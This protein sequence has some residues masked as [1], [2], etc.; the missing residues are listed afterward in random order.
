M[1]VIFLIYAIAMPGSSNQYQVH[2]VPGIAQTHGKALS[3][4]INWVV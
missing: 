3:A 4:V 2:I 1:Y